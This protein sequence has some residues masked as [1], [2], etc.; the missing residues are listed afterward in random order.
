MEQ[1]I[2]I[3]VGVLL[4]GVLYTNNTARQLLIWTAV[5]FILWC[6]GVM[7]THSN[8]WNFW[9]A[10]DFG[11]IIYPGLVV[12]II[13]FLSHPK[14]KIK[15]LG[16]A[17]KELSFAKQ[18]MIVLAV[19][20]VLLMLSLRHNRIL[21]DE[22]D[23]QAAYVMECYASADENCMRGLYG[24]NSRDWFVFF[25][26]RDYEIE[27]GVFTAGSN[28]YKKNNERN[29]NWE[30]FLQILYSL[31]TVA[32]VVNLEFQD[33]DVVPSFCPLPLKLRLSRQT[34]NEWSLG[35]TQELFFS[36]FP[37]A[38]DYVK[39]EDN[40]YFDLIATMSDEEIL[41]IVINEDVGTARYF[42]AWNHAQ[43]R[44][45]VIEPM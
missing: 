27:K 2:L 36:R 34:K 45:L 21:M 41:N 38:A 4:V 31:K 12:P 11:Y 13:V 44:H 40:Y 23:K 32:Y 9:G 39:G 19:I 15:F 7:Y 3:I 28:Q 20:A 10:R 24:P 29:Y 43:R 17:N 35:D 14:V 25:R 33:P 26:I 1:I 37:P 6:W 30:R 18:L 16:I 42:Q 8:P 22:A 5:L